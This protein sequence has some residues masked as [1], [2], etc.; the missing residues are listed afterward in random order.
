MID[1]DMYN[2]FIPCR[3]GD[4]ISPLG[5]LNK[6]EIIDIIVVRSL[7]NRNTKIILKLKDV[8]LNYIS[9]FNYVDYTWKIIQSNE[10]ELEYNEV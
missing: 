3:I 7:R 5:F 2:V 9:L 8:D 1:K 6:F 4:I 10:K